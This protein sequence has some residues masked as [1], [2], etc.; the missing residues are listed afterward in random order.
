MYKLNCNPKYTYNAPFIMKF[1][2]DECAS[3]GRIVHDIVKTWWGNENKFKAD[4]HGIYST[5][6]CD[7]HIMYTAMMFCRMFRKKI[8]THLL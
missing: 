7:S 8:P 1:E 3:Y 4:S 6:S 5:T 2:N